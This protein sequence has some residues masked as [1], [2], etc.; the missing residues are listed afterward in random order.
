[1]ECLKMKYC[2]KLKNTQ[3]WW[4]CQPGQVALATPDWRLCRT[5][6]ITMEVD[7]LLGKNY[8][9]YKAKIDALNN[10]IVNALK[11][12]KHYHLGPS[13]FAKINLYYD[14]TKKNYEEAKDKV[15]DNHISQILNEYVKGRGKE[16]EVESIRKKFI[17]K[18]HNSG[19]SDEK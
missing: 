17:S 9:D 10:A 16:N 13:Y 7:K 12:N 3:R 6:I 8:D 18:I 5:R 15:W 19:V 11:L 4:L 2:K 1:M 14:E